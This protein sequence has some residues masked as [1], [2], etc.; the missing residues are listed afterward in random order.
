MNI[1]VNQPEARPKHYIRPLVIALLFVGLLAAGLLGCF[2]PAWQ[3]LPLNTS[4]ACSVYYMGEEIN[5]AALYREKGLYL[6]FDFIKNRLDPTIKWDEKSR[7]AIV[8]AK[9]NVFHFPLGFKDGLHNLEPY[10]FSYPVL[11]EGGEVFL[12]SDPLKDFYHLEIFVDKAPSL[13]RIHNLKQP[14]QEG[15]VTAEG[16]LR[17]APSLRSPFSAVAAAGERLLIMKEDSGWYWV[18][19]EAGEMGYL[20]ESKVVLDKIKTTEIEVQVYQPWNPLRR[21]II[22]TWE[23]A[24]A[25]TV[26][27]AAL[28]GLEGVQVFSPTWFHL[29]E[30][31]LVANKADIK[32]VRWAHSKGC[33]VWGLFD[34][35]FDPELTHVF[36]NDASLRIKAIKQL[37]SYVDLYE[38]DGINL[39]F[40]NMRLEDREAFVQFA[41]ELAPLL[42][43]KERMLT[44]DVTFHSQSEN[45][46]MCYDRAGLAE[47]ADYL[48]VMGYDEH[49]GGSTKVGS[50]SSLPWVEKGLQ[51]ILEE[52]PQDKLILGIPFY[53]RLW[54][55]KTD[56]EGHRQV[57]SKAYSMDTAKDW[58]EQKRAEIR[59]DE[60]AGQNYVEVKEGD[61]TY[62]MWL[63]DSCSL[64][65]RI[66]LVKKY[67]LAGIASWRRGFESE[68]TWPMIVENMN[69]RW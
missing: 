57:D 61:T 9:E 68:D 4:E 26:N 25:K 45:W 1:P 55:E 11:E 21:P 31:G 8:T 43:A 10:S 32:Y 24:G 23:Y 46:S 41:R 22:M 63:E 47:V 56:G 34:N 50:V 54:M 13:I 3:Q 12:P 58:I 35:G 5:G 30:N 6:S 15:R 42:H 49:S 28:K 67:R 14:L 39:D 38:L 48:M 2:W 36:L 69:K 44:V 29:Q 37:L 51:R 16:K 62:K 19:T 17:H 64:M 7:M 59:F 66:E 18:E 40:E 20:P 52:V 65:S 33:Q 27:P 60:A 53:T